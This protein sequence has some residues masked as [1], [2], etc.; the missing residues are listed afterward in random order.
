VRKWLATPTGPSPTGADVINILDKL[1]EARGLPLAIGTDN[2]SPFV[3][4]DAEAYLR[5]EKVIHLRSL[6]RTPQHNG[7]AEVGIGEIKRCAQLCSAATLTVAAA[8]AHVVNAAMLLNKN[9][10]RASKGFKTAAELDEEMIVGYHQVDRDVF[11]NECCERLSEVRKKGLRPRAERM[12][13][14]EVIYGML[15][16]YKLIRRY[17]GDGQATAK[18]E[19]FL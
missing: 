18:A 13:E 3:S 5:S 8:H 17:R 19:I 6:P 1:K 4:T 7:A 14:R 15:E 11:Y 9:R 12:A 2:G 10:L 16:K